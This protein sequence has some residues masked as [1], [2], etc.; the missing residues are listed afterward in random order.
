MST[1]IKWTIEPDDI[2]WEMDWTGSK[3]NG[4]AKDKP[5]KELIFEEEAALAQ[6]LLNE[7]IH[8]NS[9]WWKYEELGEYDQ[10]A[11][12][13]A[14]NAKPDATWTKEESQL[15]SLNVGCNDVFAWGC[16]DS[17]ELPY[18]EIENLWRM[19]RKDPAWGSA[20]WC[21]IRRKH[22]PQR[23]VEKR[24]RDAGI[25]DL[26]ALKLEHGL[27][28]NHYDG[29]SHVMANQKYEAYC[30]WERSQGLDPMPFDA[31]WWDGW[32]RYTTAN[33]GW[34]DAAWKAEQDR[35]C[36]QWRQANGFR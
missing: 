5:D 34:N 12:R 7:V 2:E 16:S 10:E 20:V 32:K 23:P 4:H 11:R 33:P 6:L 3:K 28:A 17:E 30:A 19:W 36:D 9:F 27:N 13:F 18:L 35:R 29:I 31:K 1:E 15:A 8:L 22:M 14:M 26:D 25:W 24:I 21:M